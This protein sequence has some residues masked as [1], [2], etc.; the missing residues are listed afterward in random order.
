MSLK[1]RLLRTG[2]GLTCFT[3]GVLAIPH[4]WCSREAGAWYRGDPTLQQ[5]LARG[6][7][8]WVTSDLGREAFN[9]GG[10]RFDAEWLFGTY[11]MA[12]MGFGQVALEHPEMGPRLV[13]LMDA[14]IERLLSADIRSFDSMAWGADP[15][16]DL[17]SERGHAAYLGYL[18]LLL[19]LRRHLNPPSAHAALNDRITDALVHRLESTPG[20]IIS[21]YPGEGYPVDNCAVLASIGL[22]DRAT[23]G[24]RGALVKSWLQRCR[25]DWRD[26][27][28]GLL[29]QAVS[30]S[31]GTPAD[32]PRGCG[33][34]LGLYFLSF[35]DEALSRDLY[36][37]VK[38]EL[39][40]SILGFGCVRE[41]PRSTAGGRGDID[42]GPVVFGYGLSATGFC[43]GASRIH[44]DAPYFRSLCA[45]AHL[46]GA[47]LSRADRL[48]YVTGGPLGDAIMLAMLTARRTPE[49]L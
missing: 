47:P 35:I 8:A 44:N 5:K 1:R 24:T 33:T 21:T 4:R 22:H 9:T 19:S 15:L 13:P 41:Y 34:C 3:V 7:E 6:V 2:V 48:N 27:R 11:F 38:A 32:A 46:G 43:L 17:D 45:T 23:G 49:G 42:S 29:F 30:P 14:C 20:A 16:E 18:N 12:G 10:S 37:S 40:G 31:D 39:A 36:H 28:T 26:R 25:R